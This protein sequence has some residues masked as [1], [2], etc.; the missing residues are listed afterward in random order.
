MWLMSAVRDLAKLG[1]A[2]KKG[3]ISGGLMSVAST[4]L[5]L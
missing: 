1:G 5:M 4:A 3:E 2:E